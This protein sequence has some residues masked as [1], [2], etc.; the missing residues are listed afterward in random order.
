M[1]RN[2]CPVSLLSVVS[3]VFQKFV[4]NRLVNQ[5]E[6]YGFFSEFQ[7]DFR[8]SRSTADLLITVP[9]RMAKAFNRSGEL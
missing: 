4:N 2:Y 3:K 1:V 9:D 6:K 8:N 7:Y 5:P